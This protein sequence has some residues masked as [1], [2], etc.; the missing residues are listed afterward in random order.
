M[1]HFTGRLS[2]QSIYF[3]IICFALE[4]IARRVCSHMASAKQFPGGPQ[5]LVLAGPA[6][7]FGISRT[8]QRLPAYAGQERLL[9]RISSSSAW[10]AKSD[11]SENWIIEFFILWGAP[12]TMMLG[13]RLKSCTY[14]ASQNKPVKAAYR[15]VNIRIIR[16]VETKPPK[17][18]KLN[19]FNYSSQ[20]PNFQPAAAPWTP[21]AIDKVLNR[22]P[23]SSINLRNVASQ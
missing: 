11:I 4:T 13:I 18:S 6:R 1:H 19:L 17:I 16:S 14:G 3:I 7:I 15:R 20:K 2:A 9:A 22:T 8:W 21:P 23:H 5:T 12:K 10:L